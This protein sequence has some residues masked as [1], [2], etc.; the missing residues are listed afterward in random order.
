MFF[1]KKI[2][3]KNKIIGDKKIF[4][5]AEAGSNH[6]GSFKNVIKLIDIAKKSGADAVKFQLYKSENLLKKKSD[7]KNLKKYEFNRS[8]ITKTRN[9]CK[10]KNIIL[11]F[12]AFDLE[13]IDI[14]KKN[15]LAAIKIG[16]SELTNLKLVYKAAKTGL[17]LII[18]TG[19]SSMV[20]IYECLDLI[21]FAG[22]KNVVLLQCSS[23]YPS[24]YKKV[25][26]NIIRKF[27][28]HFSLPH[29]PANFKGLSES[30]W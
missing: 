29:C 14:I 27:K 7:I 8:W 4:I 6:N 23:I 13:A 26:L 16:S 28:Q 17:P 18:S 24:P 19:M 20:D 2:K 5:I 10:K 22:N 11:L 1:N 9:Y 3:I 15:N 30:C 21:K 12:S 25:N